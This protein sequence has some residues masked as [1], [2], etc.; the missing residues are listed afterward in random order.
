MIKLNQ[1]NAQLTLDQWRNIG[2]E[3]KNSEVWSARDVQLNQ[4]L[5]LK[6]ITK[7]SLAKQS[8]TDYFAEAKIL[9]ES[10]HPH[11]MPIHYSAEDKEYVYI[12]MPYYQRGSLNT[13]IQHRYLTAR[14][15]IKYSLDFLSGLLFIHIKGLLHLDIKPTNIIIDDTDRAIITDFGLSKFLDEHGFARQSMQYITHRSPEAYNTTD[16][17]VLDDIYQAGLTI[18][19]MC[20]GNDPFKEQYNA[21][22]LKHHQNGEKLK[23]SIQK[24][25][26]PDRNYYLPHIPEKLKRI[27]NKMMN[28]D[29]DKR[30]QNILSVIND[31]SKIENM[32]D[33][34]YYVDETRKEHTWTLDTERAKLSVKATFS[35]GR[36]LTSGEKLAKIS[37]N[38]QNQRRFHGSHSSK[39]EAFKFL[40]SKLNEH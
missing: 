40:K 17:T 27:V 18:Y 34:S 19:R 36:Y 29:P 8:V 30:Y 20:N 5:I 7:K 37:G 15:I 38:K 14:E 24:G 33:W 26:F 21:L 35:K 25:E 4:V 9:N 11:I 13:F 10:K 39:S 31:L 28:V 6:K 32:L 3:G 12:T 22:K 1:V 16:R 23:A 2:S